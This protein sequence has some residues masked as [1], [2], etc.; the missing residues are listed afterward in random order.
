MVGEAMAEQILTIKEVADFLKLTEKTAYRLAAEGKPRFKVGGSLRFKHSDIDAWIEESKA[1]KKIGTQIMVL[2]DK[3]S[4]Y[5][6]T[7]LKAQAYESSKL[8]RPANPS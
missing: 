7:E 4:G 1:G 6:G 3:N 5:V 8:V 2:D